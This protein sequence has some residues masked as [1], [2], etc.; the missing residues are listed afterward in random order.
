VIGVTT[1]KEV[2]EKQRIKKKGGPEESVSLSS[3][4]CDSFT[5]APDTVNVTSFSV[6]PAYAGGDLGRGG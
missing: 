1:G 6:S 2:P 5:V 4:S 3:G